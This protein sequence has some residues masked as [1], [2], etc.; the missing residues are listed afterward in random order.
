MSVSVCVHK[1]SETK[2]TNDPYHLKIDAIYSRTL[3]VRLL[4]FWRIIN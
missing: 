3:V 2:L 4:I 1:A